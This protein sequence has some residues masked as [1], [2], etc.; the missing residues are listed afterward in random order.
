M[1]AEELLPDNQNQTERH[2]VVIRK[3][4]VGAFLVNARAWCDPNTDAQQRTIAE[5]DLLALL[6]ALRALG[7]FEVFKVRDPQ[8]Q[9]LVDQY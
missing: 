3:G 9:R 2:G 8:L 6:P 7:L 5:Q 4:S 1:R